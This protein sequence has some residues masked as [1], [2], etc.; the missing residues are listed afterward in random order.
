MP[1]GKKQKPL[2]VITGSSGNIGTALRE[3]LKKDY[4]VA[5]FDQE[6]TDC[7]YPFD[8]TSEA[9]VK[10][11]FKRFKEDSS[12]D[13]IAAVIHLAAYFDFSGEDSPLY[14]AVNVNG[15][16]F[17]LETLQDFK[18]ERFIY[19]STM[20]VHKP[21]ERGELIN[22]SSELE[23]KWRYPESKLNTEKIIEQ[24]H[25]KI[26]FLIL[27]LAGL[28]NETGGVPILVQ[29][30]TRIYERSFKSHLYAGDIKAGQSFIHQ[31]D[32]IKLFEQAVKQRQNLPE[33]EIILAGESE[34]DLLYL[35]LRQ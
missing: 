13:P 27:R 29:Q 7:D 14:E 12:E 24:Y 3:A 2:I 18:V 33:K 30:I 8:I 17:L 35:Q 4:R 5:G 6:G 32:L 9:S 25:G 1:A 21:C 22:E 16:K 23:P 11:A 19:S 10:L 15:T 20:L 26:P 34:T 28:Y 31:N